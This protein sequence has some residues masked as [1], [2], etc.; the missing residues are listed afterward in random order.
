MGT[1][2]RLNVLTLKIPPCV[3]CGIVAKVTKLC[4]FIWWESVITGGSF[5]TPWGTP[6]RNTPG[7]RSARRGLALCPVS[8]TWPHKAAPGRPIPA[9]R[10]HGHSQ[11]P[12]SPLSPPF[13]WPTPP[14]PQPTHGLPLAARGPPTHASPARP[15][16]HPIC[17]RSH[18]SPSHTQT[19]IS[20]KL[21][22]K[23]GPVLNGERPFIPAQKLIV[24]EC[25]KSP[26]NA[27]CLV[28]P[29]RAPRVL[30]CQGIKD[31]LGDKHLMTS[32]LRGRRGREEGKGRN[33]EKE[34]TGGHRVCGSTG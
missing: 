20:P 2:T 1:N 34:G 17:P 10:G 11:P 6:R 15:F 30:R 5:T 27:H 24:G 21:S 16:P 22:I 23:P 7:R 8:L 3:T 31:P 18:A 12:I 33:G 9:A 14:A 25:I 28:R 32:L 13:P 29:L 19:E 26:R 4:G